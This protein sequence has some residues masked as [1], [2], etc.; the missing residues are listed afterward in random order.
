[1]LMTITNIEISNIRRFSENVRFDFVDGSGNLIEKTFILMANGTGKTTTNTLI[2]CLLDG[3][4]ESWDSDVV[5]SYKPKNRKVNEG[6]LKLHTLFDG[7]KYIYTL[8]LDYINGCAR[9]FC[10]N[11]AEGGMGR[12]RF[13][14]AIEDLFTPDFV[15]R[16]VFDGEQAERIMDTEQNEAEEAI[17]YLYR[18]DVLDE[19]LRLNESILKQ[20]QEDAGGIGTKQSVKNLKS[21]QEK[22]RKTIVRLQQ[23]SDTLYSDIASLNKKAEDLETKI[24]KIDEKSQDLFRKKTDAENDV[25]KLKKDIEV[26]I[27]QIMSLLKSPYLVSATICNRMTEFGNSMTKLKLPKT[28]SKDFFKELSN[29]DTCICGRHIGKKEKKCIQDNADKY[30][31]SDQQAVLNNIK[32]NLVNSEYNDSLSEHFNSIR[33]LSVDLKRA[34]DRVSKIDNQLAKAGG[35]EAIS[36]RKER[37]IILGQKGQKE[38]EVKI[39]TKRNDQDPSLTEENNLPK[40]E[41]AFKDFEIKIAN[42]TATNNALNRKEVVEKI[43]NEIK[44]VATEKLKD[45]IIRKTNEKIR[46]VITDDDI[47]IE[48]IENCLK[49]KDREHGSAGQELSVAYCFI[50]TLFENSQLRFPFIIDSPC[51]SMDFQKRTAI[52]SILPKLFNQMIVY[53]MSAEVERFADQYYDQ[54]STQFLTVIP[55]ADSG[56][57][58]IHAGKEFFDKYQREHREEEK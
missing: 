38:T 49:L 42:A 2:K 45:E 56:E 33:K 48:S 24:K 35:E 50:G 8:K 19:I 3:T 27:A 30:L 34:E 12:R 5:R 17:K 58:E 55:D 22:I 21:R 10:T 4:A 57:I 20:K 31:G 26:E 46:N 40:A 37:D 23:R 9:I 54:K 11:A 47:E 32:S 13:P 16:F 7:N 29:Q 39:I 14:I 15:H 1:M 52:A 44:T 18:L 36:L 6:E 51:G 53:V 41:D 43:I 25:L 28:I